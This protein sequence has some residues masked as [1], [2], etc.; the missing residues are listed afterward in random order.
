MLESLG[1]LFKEQRDLWCAN[2]TLCHLNLADYFEGEFFPHQ[3]TPVWPTSSN[4]CDDI[5]CI[6][7]SH[8][9]GDESEDVDTLYDD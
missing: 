2:T 9:V 7:E 4:Q 8:M 6:I 1:N 5:V 3:T